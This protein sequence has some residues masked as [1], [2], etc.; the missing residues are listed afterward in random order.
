MKR[1]SLLSLFCVVGI[2][3]VAG[4]SDSAAPAA[5]GA[6]MNDGAM[7]SDMKGDGMMK[8]DMQGEG[9]MKGEAMKGDGMMKEESK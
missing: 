9:M 8:G 1:L 2:S 4:C 6:L 7:K 3:V 5:G